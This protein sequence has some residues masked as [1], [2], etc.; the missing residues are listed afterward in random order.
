MPCLVGRI[1]TTRMG[2][3][4]ARRLS[5]EFRILPLAIP[6][7]IKLIG[8]ILSVRLR[9]YL[10]NFWAEPPTSSVLNNLSLIIQ[11]VHR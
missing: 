10:L 4:H 3:L 8:Y 9:F 2:F 6:F 5:T 7:P 1:Q 11:H